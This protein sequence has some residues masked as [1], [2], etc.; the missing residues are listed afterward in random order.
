M[1][2]DIIDNEQ[3]LPVHSQGGKSLIP[4]PLRFWPP[5]MCIAKYIKSFM[6][7]WSVIELHVRLYIMW[8]TSFSKLEY[9]NFTFKIE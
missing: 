7:R 2:E 4:N 1:W 5:L 8:P 9:R 6:V 3:S